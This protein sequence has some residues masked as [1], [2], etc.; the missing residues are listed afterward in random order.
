MYQVI[1]LSLDLAATVGYFP[2]PAVA[3]LTRQRPAAMLD[4]NR[5]SETR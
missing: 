4:V 2:F 1:F 5:V 3:M